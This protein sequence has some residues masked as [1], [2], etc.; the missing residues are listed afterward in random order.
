[1]SAV[2]DVGDGDDVRAALVN[3]GASSATPD[4]GVPTRAAQEGDGGALSVASDV[5]YALSDAPVNPRALPMMPTPALA[6]LQKK[7]RAP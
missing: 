3:R 6:S 4:V 5:G 1:M 7:R 2:P